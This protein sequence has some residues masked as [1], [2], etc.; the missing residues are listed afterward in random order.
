MAQSGENCLIFNTPCKGKSPANSNSYA[1]GKHELSLF[2]FQYCM[3]AHL[4]ILLSKTAKF[5]AYFSF[6]QYIF[7]LL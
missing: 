6:R 5:V 7:K 1:G 4:K 3:Y 2:L